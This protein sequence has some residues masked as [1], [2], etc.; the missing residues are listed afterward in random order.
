MK[1]KPSHIQA[2]V[3]FLYAHFYLYQAYSYLCSC[4]HIVKEGNI[5]W[6]YNLL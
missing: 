2:Y 4:V 6:C 5:L 1:K 3:S